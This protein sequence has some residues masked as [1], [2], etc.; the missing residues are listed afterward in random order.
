MPL[1][2]G[3]RALLYQ[4]DHGTASEVKKLIIIGGGSI[5]EYIGPE[6]THV[7]A[8]TGWD[9]HFDDASGVAPGA[10]FVHSSFIITS[11]KSGAL[12]LV[13][14]HAVANPRP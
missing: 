2:T 14:E 9:E 10:A 11:A 12:A 4:L 7:V 3:V 5:S 6:V 8:D 13:S 1:R